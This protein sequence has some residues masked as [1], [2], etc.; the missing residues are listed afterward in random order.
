MEPDGSGGS[1]N[2]ITADPQWNHEDTRDPNAPPPGIAAPSVFNGPGS[3]A[4]GERGD[5]LDGMKGKTSKAAPGAPPH[6][7]TMIITSR[8]RRGQDRRM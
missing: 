2:V 3:G 7:G 6:P 4:A 8:I 1:P 5:W